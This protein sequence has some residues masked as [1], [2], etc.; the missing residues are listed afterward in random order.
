[1]KNLPLLFAICGLVTSCAPMHVTEVPLSSGHAVAYLGGGCF[2]C[3]EAVFE[4]EPGVVSVVSGYAGGT[5]E[6]PTYRDVCSGTTGHAEV[7]RIEFDP[8]KTSYDRLLT[9]FFAA[10]DPTTMNRQGPDE[11]TQYRS[12]I[13]VTDAAQ[14]A[15]AEKALAEAQKKY[16]GGVVTEVVPLVKFFPAEDYHQ[17]YFRKHPD[18]QYCRIMIAPKLKK[19]GRH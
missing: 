11:G 4:T 16:D 6:N 14:K 8:T 3:L 13:L 5:V 17:H 10:H 9:L 2:W 12:I 18:Q 7:V 19:L 15:V 1:M